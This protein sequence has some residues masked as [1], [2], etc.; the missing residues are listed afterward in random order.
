MTIKNSFAGN[1]YDD[2]ED[3]KLAIQQFFDSKNEDFFNGLFLAWMDRL[4]KCIIAKGD[5]FH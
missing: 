2:S 4:R 1:D 3:L 5:Y